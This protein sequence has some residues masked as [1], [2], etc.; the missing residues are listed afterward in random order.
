MNESSAKAVF[1]REPE[2]NP[3]WIQFF[4]EVFRLQE[5]ASQ[6]RAAAKDQPENCGTYEERVGNDQVSP[7]A[8]AMEAAG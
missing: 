7:N 3:A 4:A 5:V 2:L 1:K 8:P 6:R